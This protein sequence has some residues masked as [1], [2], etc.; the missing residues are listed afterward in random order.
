MNGT[1]RRK[2]QDFLDN[3]RDISQFMTEEERKQIHE[4]I[5]EEEAQGGAVAYEM[6]LDFVEDKNL[7]V[8]F[9]VNDYRQILDTLKK[10]N[11][12]FSTYD[13]QKNYEDEFEI[14]YFQ[15]VV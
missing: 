1:K 12:T 9:D 11:A 14:T 15:G 5:L 4:K 3:M 13:L 7:N 2:Y 8:P 6:I 10:K